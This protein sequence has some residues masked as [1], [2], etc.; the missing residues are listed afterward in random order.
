MENNLVLSQRNQVWLQVK[1]SQ[2]QLVSSLTSSCSPSLIGCSTRES[3]WSS[4]P[5]RSP[6]SRTSRS[7]PPVSHNPT[8]PDTP[9]LCRPPPLPPPRSSSSRR[10]QHHNIQPRPVHT[11]DTP[12]E[13]NTWTTARRTGRPGDSERNSLQRQRQS[14]RQTRGQWTGVKVQSWTSD[15]YLGKKVC[16]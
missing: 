6:G 14:N 2:W 1:H 9:P 3:R 12:P 5:D 15:Q 8:R 13:L 10:P 4:T 11:P 16:Q 7:S